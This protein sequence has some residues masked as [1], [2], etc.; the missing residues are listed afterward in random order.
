MIDCFI[1]VYNTREVPLSYVVRKDYMG[2]VADNTREE[3]VIHHAI[4][5][6]PMFNQD[7]KN[8]MQLLKDL[9]SGAPAYNCIKQVNCGRVSMHKVQEH[10]V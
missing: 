6:G 2:Y 1:S 10:P 5:N 3:E 7:S 4:L 9:S 8:V